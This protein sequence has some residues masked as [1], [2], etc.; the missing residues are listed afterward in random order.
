MNQDEE[1]VEGVGRER[2]R[3]AGFA[4]KPEIAFAVLR[5]ARPNLH[6]GCTGLEQ[7]RSAAGPDLDPGSFGQ[8]RFQQFDHSVADHAF[9][10]LV[11]GGRW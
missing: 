3:D 6:N 10:F 5:V 8:R 1:R 7:W 4:A 11:H 9:E 2:G